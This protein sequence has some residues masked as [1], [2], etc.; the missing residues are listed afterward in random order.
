MVETGSS[1]GIKGTITGCKSELIRDYSYLGTFSFRYR[2]ITLQITFY[3]F[4]RLQG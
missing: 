4:T 3:S 1:I 2:N